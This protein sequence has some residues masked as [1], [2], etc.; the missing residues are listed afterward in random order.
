MTL[1]LVSNENHGSYNESLNRS[2]T[3]NSTSLELILGPPPIEGRANFADSVVEKTLEKIKE[4]TRERAQLELKGES[5]DAI[6]QNIELNHHEKEIYKALIEFDRTQSKKAKELNVKIPL[7]TLGKAVHAFMLRVQ[8][9]L[10]D[11]FQ[12]NNTFPT[13]ESF[14]SEWKEYYGHHIEEMNEIILNREYTKR[15]KEE[16]ELRKAAAAKKASVPTLQVT[17]EV[18]LQAPPPE[19]GAL[20]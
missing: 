20:H 7:T 3:E 15:L 5:N 2:A 19:G 4:N 8:D 11:Y 10:E 9:R 18:A 1:F 16:I 14:Q 13:S 17:P 12:L 6:G